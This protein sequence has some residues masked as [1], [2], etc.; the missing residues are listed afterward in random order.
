MQAENEDFEL[1]KENTGI[2]LKKRSRLK[3][4]ADS[5][6]D[7]T[8]VKKEIEVSY[9][10]AQQEK[11]GEIKQI[12]TSGGFRKGGRDVYKSEYPRENLEYSSKNVAAK[13][14]KAKRYEDD[15]DFGQGRENQMNSTLADFPM[16]EAFN[17]DEIDD[18][19]TTA[20]DKEVVDTDIPERLQIKLK[21]RLNPT[22]EE[23]NEEAEWILDR[24]CNH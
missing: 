2:E 1:I 11:S 15:N 10:A 18:P 9:D 19:F 13:V 22:K 20:Y 4:N 16:E 24:L 17:A 12:D 7:A 14:K 23:L 3:R 5:N 6:V 21:D 8:Q